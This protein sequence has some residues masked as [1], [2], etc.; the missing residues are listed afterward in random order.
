[1]RQILL[2]KNLSFFSKFI[3]KRVCL[4]YSSVIAANKAA[5]QQQ[6]IAQLQRLLQVAR[7]GKHSASAGYSA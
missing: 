6:G 1:M 2:Q 4:G 3:E 7:L 5:K